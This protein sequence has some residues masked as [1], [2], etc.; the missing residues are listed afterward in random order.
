MTSSYEDI[1]FYLDLSKELIKK[2][3]II[4]TIRYY[5]T[6]KN[7]VNL[8]G[9]YGL[10]IFQEEGNPIFI[11]DKKDS[12]IIINAIEENWKSRPKNQSFFENGLFYVFSYLTEKIRKKSK[13]YRIIIITD[14][15][16]DLSEDYIR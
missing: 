1:F 8:Q 7:K 10:L 16:S 2:K 14:T 3:D 13:T 5:I 9:H 4:K 6:E 12:N 15:P 11:T